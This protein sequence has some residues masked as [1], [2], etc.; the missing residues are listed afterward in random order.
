VN[1]VA[2]S[3]KRSELMSENFLFDDDKGH[4]RSRLFG[5]RVVI[6]DSLIYASMYR[7][8][9]EIFKSGAIMI[10]YETGK[11]AGRSYGK[12]LKDKIGEPQQMAGTLGRLG[13]ASGWGKIDFSPLSLVTWTLQEKVILKIR[14]NFHAEAVGQTGESSCHFIRGLFIGVFEAMFGGEFVCNE[15]KC[16]SK[17]DSYCEFQLKRP[18]TGS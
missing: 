18:S 10:L 1:L 13:A 7:R 3:R 11:E 12:S 9:F 6:Y 5:T 15:S 4:I 16:Q 14:N 8:M 2:V 17:G